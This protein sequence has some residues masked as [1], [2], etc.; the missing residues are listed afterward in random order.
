MLIEV[1][2]GDWMGKVLTLVPA[3]LEPAVLACVK[4]RTQRPVCRFIDTHFIPLRDMFQTGEM[5]QRLR[6][7]AASLEVLSSVPS[8]NMV[9]HNQRQNTVHIINNSLKK[10]ERERHVL[11]STK[12]YTWSPASSISSVAL[13]ASFSY[14]QV[15]GFLCL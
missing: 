6:T 8:N 15:S 11:T 13:P 5:A 9:T 3:S 12:L 10:S 7:L 4:K 2:Q 14:L 1:M